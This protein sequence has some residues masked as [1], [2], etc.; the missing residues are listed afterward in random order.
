MPLLIASRSRMYLTCVH[1][2]HLD[3]TAQRCAAP[4]VTMTAC[5]EMMRT[6]PAGSGSFPVPRAGVRFLGGMAC[7]WVARVIYGSCSLS[8]VYAMV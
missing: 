3:G 5:T 8:P 2:A 1:R 4:S 7:R 6:A